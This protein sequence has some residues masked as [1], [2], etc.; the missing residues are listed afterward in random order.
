[1]VLGRYGAAGRWRHTIEVSG[2][3]CGRARHCEVI[4]K[5]I[6]SR[7]RI[8]T[9]PLQQLDQ[10]KA[11][12]A[13]ATGWLRFVGVSIDPQTGQTQEAD[14]RRMRAEAS[15]TTSSADADSP[16]LVTSTLK[17]LSR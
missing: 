1:M 12:R 5:R 3:V 2:R 17:R 15:V 11:N 6:T 4:L 13:V 9:G 10:D 7:L 14:W 16:D 8:A